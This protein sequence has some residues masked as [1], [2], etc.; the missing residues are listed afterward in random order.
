MYLRL[1][2][3]TK[4]QVLFMKKNIEK[5]KTNLII[6]L[7]FSFFLMG[8]INVSSQTITT[9]S[10]CKKKYVSVDVHKTYERVIAKGYESIEMFEYLGD[11]YYRINELEKSKLYFELLF[12]KYKTSQIS[13]RTIE[14]YNSIKELAK[15]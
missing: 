11:Y 12:R 10:I 8:V 13:A 5:P 15:S 2:Y 6:L 14:L 4:P 9:D 7:V 3:L 1:P